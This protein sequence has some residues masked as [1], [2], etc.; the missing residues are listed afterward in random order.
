MGLAQRVFRRAVRA[1]D[2]KVLKR[3][4]DVWHS[5]KNVIE[6]EHNAKDREWMQLMM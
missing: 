5:W 3:A 4:P 1:Y 2:T 6:F